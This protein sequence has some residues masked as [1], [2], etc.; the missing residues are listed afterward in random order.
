MENISDKRLTLQRQTWRL[1]IANRRRRMIIQQRTN[2]LSTLRRIYIKRI[3]TC[4]P[5]FCRS[6]VKLKN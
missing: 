4:I 5:H 3:L 6:I 1:N 2:E